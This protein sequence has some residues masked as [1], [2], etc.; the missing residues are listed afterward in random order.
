MKQS[1][2]HSF[3]D[4]RTWR[5]ILPAALLNSL[6][7][8]IF[9]SA[10]STQQVVVDRTL[11]DY[12]RT[13]Y[14]ILVRAPENVTEVEK[15][16]GLVEANHLNGTAGGITMQQYEQIKA[17]SG[18]EVAA[19]IAMLGY[20][21]RGSMGVAIQEDLPAGIYRVSASAGILAGEEYVTEASLT[22]YYALHTPES[23]DILGLSST[24]YEGWAEE[25]Q[26]LRLSITF[27]GASPITWMH[28]WY[29]FPVP[30]I[31]CSSLLSILNRKPS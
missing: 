20:M 7:L 16:Y 5:A 24:K 12:Q 21:N 9:F 27:G 26:R 10:L 29:P 8:V 30:M 2:A 15:E 25:L 19:P 1:Y 14:D 13:T 18:V 17:I 11:T 31:A 3:L 4:S 6:V 23:S 28:F 22:P